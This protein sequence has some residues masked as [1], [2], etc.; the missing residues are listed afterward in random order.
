[1]S[2]PDPMPAAD[3]T[4]ELMAALDAFGRGFEQ[5]CAAAARLG[6]EVLAELARVRVALDAIDMRQVPHADPGPAAPVIREKRRARSA[7][8]VPAKRAR[9]DSGR[10]HADWTAERD[11]MLRRD[12]G[13]TDPS[14]VLANLNRLPGR[15]PIPS[16]GAIR[17]RARNFGLS[18]HGDATVTATPPGPDDQV[19]AEVSEPS[20][21][22][23]P[24]APIVD[25]TLISPDDPEPVPIMDPAPAVGPTRDA[26]FVGFSVAAAL[27]ADLLR[28]AAASPVTIDT[29]RE[30]ARNNR[31]GA[32]TSDRDLL[33]AVN[34]A[35]QRESLPPFTLVPRRTLRPE[36]RFP[37]L[38]VGPDGEAFVAKVDR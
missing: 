28:Q 6:Q 11:A 22:P 20:A 18:R 3:Q 17:S 24:A 10:A 19:A 36:P 29:V 37:S 5:V 34:T 16:V 4:A 27:E 25:T 21:P 13:R 31:L 35:R 23:P 32:F 15:R 26:R 33:A 9:S 2:R 1:M 14:E 12:W 30:W 7:V 8:P 38:H